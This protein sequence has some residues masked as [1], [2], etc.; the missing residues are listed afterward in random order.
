[1]ILTKLS[2]GDFEKILL[3]YNI[4]TYMS[5]KHLPEAL[6]T[7]CYK[8]ATS[9]G[10]FI[11]NVFEKTP[12]KQVIFQLKVLDILTKNKFDT[13]ALIKTKNKK[14]YITYNKKR[15]FI[16]EFFNGSRAHGFSNKEIAALGIKIAKLHK[17]LSKLK[18]GYCFALR[19][20]KFNELLAPYGLRDTQTK[21]NI[22]IKKIDFSKLKK[23][24][25]HGDITP[26]NLLRSKQG[27][28]V[29]I[30]WDD[31]HADTYIY[32]LAVFITHILV[33]HKIIYKKQIKILI[34]SYEKLAGKLNADEKKAL[35]I[36][37][38]D[39]FL[40]ALEWCAIQMRTHKDREKEIHSWLI[41]VL[42]KQKLFA[43]WPLEDFLRNIE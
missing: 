43:K 14:Y 1:M 22:A 5:H 16:Q 41:A 13:P 33:K 18:I 11:L 8:L 29:F 20:R 6:E 15:I 38:I 36:A 35:Y 30:D 2:K 10:K 37:V 23:G 42:N 24:V 9:E 32:E 26:A 39:R 4:G 12:Q 40:S 19:Q 34:K 27:K 17:F 28:I 31:M 3:K 7:S 21:V 25:I